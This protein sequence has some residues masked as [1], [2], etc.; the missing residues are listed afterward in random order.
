MGKSR[1]GTRVRRGMAGGCRPGWRFLLMGL[2]PGEQPLA[3]HLLACLGPWPPAGPPVG[4]CGA[5]EVAVGWRRDSAG[6]AA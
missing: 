1:P 6:F 2:M 3:P 4:G 5:E